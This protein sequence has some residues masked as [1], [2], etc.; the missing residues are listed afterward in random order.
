MAEAFKTHRAWEDWILV[1]I[2]VLIG[3]SPWL[4]EHDRS[5]LITW[6]AS[7]LGGAVIALAVLELTALQRWEE[8]LAMLCGFW[9][10]ALPFALDYIEDALGVWHLALGV[11]LVLLSALQLWQDWHRSD[12]EMAEPNSYKT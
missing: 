11:L 5:P 3:V 10:L 6:N 2:G 4:A 8:M 7:L 12:A 9:L 1:G